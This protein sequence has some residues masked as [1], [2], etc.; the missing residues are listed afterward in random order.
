[1]NGSSGM[2]GMD[3]LKRMKRMKLGDSGIEVGELCL[4]ILPIGPLQKN[5]PVEEASEVIAE[6]LRQGVDFIDTAQMYRTYPHIKRAL[7]KVDKIPVIASKSH[8]ATYEGMEAA[9]LEAL[10]AMG[11]STIDIFHLHAAKV[12][13]DVFDLRSGA[14][15]CLQDYKKKG[16]IRAAGIST[17]NPKVVEAA[18]HRSDIDVVFALINVAGRGIYNGSQEEMEA[19]I[20]L[21][22]EKGKGVYLMKVLGGGT[23]SAEFEKSIT[24]ARGL[25]EFPLAIGMI[26]MD[27]V[28]YNLKYFKNDPSYKEVPLE[29]VQK[30][31][32][33]FGMV[34]KSCGTCFD[35]C[36]SEA[37]SYGDDGKAW[38]DPDKCIQCGYCISACPHFAIRMM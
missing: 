29:L 35:A 11:I 19:A 4:G 17:H 6:A 20:R 2:N 27:E 22:R 1:M 18:A 30:N 25:G 36:H 12:E 8:E 37:I 24:Y 21:C 32:F 9:I 5:V 33:V 28:D 23:L 16:I 15:Q 3:E 26:R 31:I 34:C 14:L 7:E 38:I 13:T 10:E